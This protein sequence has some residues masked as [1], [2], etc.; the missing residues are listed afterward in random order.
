MHES[1]SQFEKLT[2]CFDTINYQ[3]PHF[4]RQSILSPKKPLEI[5]SNLVLRP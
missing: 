2:S 4:Y 5:S 3:A 1:L